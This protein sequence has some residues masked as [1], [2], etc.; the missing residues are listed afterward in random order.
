M[1][2]EKTK[3]YLFDFDGTLTKGQTF[4]LFL[5]HM[6]AS[7]RQI[8]LYKCRNLLAKLHLIS[9]DE[10]MEH[11]LRS[12]LRDYTQQ[13]YEAKCQS[14]ADVIDKMNSAS[15]MGIVAH[16][17][18][19]DIKIRIV[20]ESLKDLIYPWARRHGITDVTATEW[21]QNSLQLTTPVCDGVERVHR[22]AP[23]YIPRDEY[24]IT[25][26]GDSRGADEKR[27]DSP[28]FLFADS[29]LHLH[30]GR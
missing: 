22:L 17:Q 19:H 8:F 23:I 30:R 24:L 26:F 5:R 15:G 18:A 1:N 28:M 25:A 10:A 9:R 20:S 29:W 12:I 14:F 27:G 2:A 3:V 13:E 6:G 21:D 11:T 7:K 4:M 16:A